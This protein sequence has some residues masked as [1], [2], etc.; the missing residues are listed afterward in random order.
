MSRAFPLRMGLRRRIF[1]LK[2]Y[3]SSHPRPVPEGTD[4]VYHPSRPTRRTPPTRRGFTL[5]E[6]LVVIAI[7][8]ILIG[9]LLPA[10]QK[11]REAA[12]RT[13]CQNNLKQIGLAL[14]NYATNKSGKFPAA[15]IHSG[16]SGYLPGYNGP[17]V[18][19][20][21]Q[22]APLRLQ[23][24][25]VR[26]PAAVHRAGRPVHSS[27]TT[28]PRSAARR[29]G[30]HAGHQP[31]GYAGPAYAQNWR[32]L[33]SRSRS[34]PARRTRTRR[35]SVRGVAGHASRSGGPTTCSAPARRPSRAATAYDRGGRLRHVPEDGHRPEL[36]RG[37]R[38]G[39]GGER[40]PD[41][42]RVE[43]HDRGR[44]SPSRSTPWRR[45]ARSG[46]SAPS[47]PGPTHGAVMG[48][49]VPATTTGRGVPAQR[50]G[51]HLCR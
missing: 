11:V 2:D 15:V 10:V 29:S 32:S 46:A 48:I 17:E 1:H 45:P 27:T 5:I 35:R 26:G 24:Q 47:G 41:E 19:Y 51:R 13:K 34:T 43:Q 44:A 20:I 8:A 12:A 22:S 25:R 16:R 42:G 37:V 40:R 9:L 21:G 30:R 14:H 31:A 4:R 50:Q 49:S 6:L 23:P 36:P 38:A 3:V 33:T 39:R 28:G 18:N 7:I